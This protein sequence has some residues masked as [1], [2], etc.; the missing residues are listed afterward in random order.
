[1]EE[2]SGERRNE[3]CENEVEKTEKVE[4]KHKK[5]QKKLL[6]ELQEQIKFY[7]SGPNLQKD[8]FLR[9][10]ITESENGC[11]EIKT[12]ASF[13]RMK[14]LCDDI[15]LIVKA[16]KLCPSVE[17]IDDKWVKP[18]QPL[19]QPKN[20]DS[21]TVY[22]ER[23]P[24]NADHNWIKS[25]F[26]SCGTV[27][28]ISLP[29]FAETREIKGFAF[30]EFEKES[31]AEAALKM[32]AEE[33]NDEGEDQPEDKPQDDHDVIDEHAEKQNKKTKKRKAKVSESESD[34]MKGKCKRSKRRKEGSSS[35]ISD[36]IETSH[37]RS[38]NVKNE[39][40]KDVEGS[41][42]KEVCEESSGNEASG[43]DNEPKG[44]DD[45]PDRTERKERKRRRS[46]ASDDEED[47][48]SKK[49]KE[50]SEAED[51]GGASSKKNDCEANAQGD[52]GEMGGANKKKK[53]RKRK[54]KEKQKVEVPR[55]RVISKKDWLKM[56]QEYLN[57]QKAAMGEAK[58]KLRKESKKKTE[59]ASE[60]AA[61]TQEDDSDRTSGRGSEGRSDEK[62]SKAVKDLPE[63]LKMQHGV[64]LK[65]S[66][67]DKINNSQLR[68]VFSNI[69]PVL[70]LDKDLDSNTGYVRF[71][72]KE[73]CDKVADSFSKTGSLE[74]ITVRKLTENEDT[75]Y[76]EQINSDRF[77]RLQQGNKQNRNKRG[78]QKI[79]KKMDDRNAKKQVHVHFED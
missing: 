47:T 8:R 42:K 10:K 25:L 35:T 70:Y 57:L 48:T 5:R 1:M 50:S 9:K 36:A 45:V 29:R 55:L 33:K 34:D 2:D 59:L 62:A 24:S 63:K 75:D 39:Q 13:N 43:K 37:D 66:C 18:S 46:E 73:A 20:V 27:V 74:N 19:P 3:S 11:V 49:I 12:I 15:T 69:A 23:L 72:T 60:T 40:K 31:E 68:G 17:V 64:V 51:V 16:M 53:K 32:F 4:K 79:T 58:E 71:A 41:I 77:K 26:S 38:R 14:Q 78:R 56:K 30:V 28:Y 61:K 44:S 7:F 6:G 76:W 21:V 65:F 67:E 52:A 54:R 22:V